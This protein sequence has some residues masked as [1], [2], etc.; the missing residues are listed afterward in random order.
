MTAVQVFATGALAALV[1]APLPVRLV[2]GAGSEVASVAGPVSFIGSPEVARVGTFAAT[3]NGERRTWYSV[4]GT[5]GGRPYDS[6]AWLELPGGET[7]I[8]AG[9]FDT[10]DPPMDTFQWGENGMPSSFGDYR[11]STLGI[12][13]S[14]AGTTPPFSIEFPDDGALS[15]VSYQ[16]VA[17]LETMVETSFMLQEGTLHITVAEISGGV[18][19]LEGTF[20]GTFRTLA[21]AEAV[22]ITDGT[23]QVQ[24][25]PGL[26]TMV[27]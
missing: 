17:D 22:Q 9:G 21:G 11:G 18:A 14:T 5:S 23:F 25:I 4:S 12:A 6:S 16:P 2:E 26:T 24:E 10:P 1:L 7:L 19:R 3:I 20:S 15:L 27:R 8:T 13:V